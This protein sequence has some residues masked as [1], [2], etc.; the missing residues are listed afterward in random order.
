MMREMWRLTDVNLVIFGADG[1]FDRG[2]VVQVVNRSKRV[3]QGR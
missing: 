2:S 3:Y 1:L